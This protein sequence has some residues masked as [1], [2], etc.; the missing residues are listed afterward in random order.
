MKLDQFLN[1][2]SFIAFIVFLIAALT[3]FWP[4]YFGRI[5]SPTV[6][7]HLHRHGL[8]MILWCAMLIAQAVLIRNRQNSLH[9]WIGYSSYVLVPIMVVTAFDLVNH[10]FHGA[11]RLAAGHF[12]FIALS[13]NAIFAFLTLY[14]LAIYFRKHSL[15]HAR[16]MVVTALPLI[17]PITDRLIYRYVKPIIPYA[18]KIGNM[19]IVPF[20][21]FLIA[22][23]ILVGLIIWDGYSNKRWNVFP[24]ALVILLIYHY[25]VMNFYKYDFWQQFCYWFISLPPD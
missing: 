1:K 13:V 18:P 15:I 22:D 23:T 21:G 7:G 4:G 20:Y 24:V 14:G 17:S 3:A 2:K 19:P 5:L 6:D 9:K 25:S 8:A 12:Y 11:Q 16:F 10:L